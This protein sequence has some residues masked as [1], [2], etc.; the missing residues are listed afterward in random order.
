[1]ISR[2][3]TNL[4]KTRQSDVKRRVDLSHA[5]MRDGK[6][7]SVCRVPSPLNGEKVAEGRMRG[8]LTCDFGLRFA[9]GCSQPTSSP[10]PMNPTLIANITLRYDFNL[11]NPHPGPLPSDGRGGACASASSATGH[12]NVTALPVPSPIGWER[13]RVRVA[14]Q[15]LK[16]LVKF[17]GSRRDWFRRILSP[18]RK[19]GTDYRVEKTLLPHS[20]STSFAGL[21]FA[22]RASLLST[23]Q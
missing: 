17:R 6:A 15:T 13:V 3:T 9:G 1:M 5:E 8:G 4:R 11:F 23:N 7:T 21:A 14:P 2:I 16:T 20:L 22:H 19:E 10:L 12:L 18:L